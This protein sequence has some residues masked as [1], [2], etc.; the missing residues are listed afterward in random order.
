MARRIIP[1][2]CLALL[3]ATTI[4]CGSEG[5]DAPTTT[6][7]SAKGGFAVTIDGQSFSIDYAVGKTTVDLVHKLNSDAKGYGCI[8][9][10]RIRMSRDDDT[11][12]LTLRYE[13]K[14]GELQLVEASFA[15][16]EP[17]EQAGAIIG[18]RSCAGFPGIEGGGTIVYKLAGGTGTLSTPPLGPG[19]ANQ[20]HAT[21]EGRTLAPKG[22]IQLHYKGKLFDLDT[23]AIQVSGDLVS[24]GSTTVSCGTAVGT[25]LCPQGVSYGADLGE[26]VRRPGAA[27]A[28]TDAGAYDLGEFCGKPLMLFAYQ[29]W[30]ANPARNP[31]GHEKFSGKAILEGMA[32][33]VDKYGSDIAFAI[34]VLSGSQK[35]VVENPAEP[36]KYQ[37]S[38]P[39]PTQADCDAIRTAYGIPE[40]VVM[41]YDQDM[42]LNG[43]DKRLVGV[44]FTPS[45]LTADSQ[46]KIV[47]L[48]PGADG[49]MELAAVEAA[50]EAAIAA[51]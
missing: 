14:G 51:N 15:A 11:C 4:G 45:M 16:I 48:L 49:K 28:C 47:A 7:P 43:T 22:T 5:E 31:D 2:A 1:F 12:P 25:D 39:A 35:V 37:A 6:A 21:L 30:V 8:T 13:P 41:L 24:T 40:D 46:G 9:S 33:L 36:G 26:Y 34:V 20:E 10:L 42:V 38:G 23:S 19:E 3:T 32:G 50:I 18:S 27:Y 29:H 17:I 44:N